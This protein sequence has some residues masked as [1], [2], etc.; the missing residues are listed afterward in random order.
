MAFVSESFWFNF[1]YPLLQVTGR[2]FLLTTTPAALGSFFDVFSKSV[3]KQNRENNLFFYL[4]NHSLVCERCWEKN[5]PARCSHLLYLIPP[6]KSILRFHNL[7]RLVPSKQ[8]E[9]FET[10][11]EPSLRV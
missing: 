3:Q 8:Q 6:W 2:I 10:E 4:I 5:E 9:N 7:K 1:A 11:G